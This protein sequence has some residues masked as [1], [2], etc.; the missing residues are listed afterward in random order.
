MGKEQTLGASELAAARPDS[1][2]TSN[3]T[4]AVVSPKVVGGGVGA[5]VRPEQPPDVASKWVWRHGEWC[6]APGSYD[7]ARQQA[8][9]I[10]LK[11]SEVARQQLTGTQGEAR[12]QALKEAALQNPMGSA[13]LKASE[14]AAPTTNIAEAA[15]AYQAMKRDEGVTISLADATRAIAPR[16]QR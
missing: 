15:L 4:S 5:R 10:P 8:L 13:P 3:P 2:R 6:I 7:L 11:A 16:R 12:Y 14:Y 9:G 1:V